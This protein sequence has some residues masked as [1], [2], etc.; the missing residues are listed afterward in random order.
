MD[1]LQPFWFYFG[2]ETFEKVT[3]DRKTTVEPMIS[4][5]GGT[6]G[7]FTGFSIFSAIEILYFI[8]KCQSC[9]WA[10]PKEWIMGTWKLPSVSGKIV[11]I[12]KTQLKRSMYVPWEGAGGFQVPKS[13]NKSETFLKSNGCQTVRHICSI[14]VNNN[15]NLSPSVNQIM[16]IRIQLVFCKQ[17]CL[18]KNWSYDSQVWR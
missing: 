13:C 11:S 6:M 17:E 2:T 3:K 5:I 4:L 14:N 1:L 16:K 15:L 8:A 12:I 10:F 9:Q 7:L 18:F